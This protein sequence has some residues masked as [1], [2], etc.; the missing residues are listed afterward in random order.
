MSRISTPIN[1]YVK[2]SFVE[3]ITGKR[4]LNTDWEAYKQ[5]LEKLGYSEYINHMQ[6]AY[7]QIKK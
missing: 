6:T 4:N 3:F 5:N 1:D 2:N 7:D